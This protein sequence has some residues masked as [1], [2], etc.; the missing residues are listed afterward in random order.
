MGIPTAIFDLAGE[1]VDH[2]MIHRA[3][4]VPVVAARNSRFE[5]AR[6]PADVHPCSC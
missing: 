4:P 6:E 1:L 3:E 2:Q 5:S